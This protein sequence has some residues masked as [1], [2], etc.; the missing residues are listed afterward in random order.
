MAESNILVVDDEKN[1]LLTVRHALE[2]QGYTVVT[3]ATGEEALRLLEQRVFDLMLLDLRLPGIDGMSV[4]KQ[5]GEKQPNVPV[6]IISAYGTVGNAVEAMK[7]GA[8]DFL[9]KPFSPEELRETVR[10]ILARRDLAGSAAADYT[11]SITRSKQ[12]AGERHLTAASEHARRAIGI[13]PSRPEAFN[14]LGAYAEARGD[15]LTAQKYYR[16]ALELDPAYAPSRHNL[17]RLVDRKQ[18]QVDLGQE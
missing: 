17:S 14:L 13:E 6:V 4:L 1:I 10:R 18:G 2:P 15:S 12:C 9:E 5:V 7:L 16:T 3:A 11:S 8:I